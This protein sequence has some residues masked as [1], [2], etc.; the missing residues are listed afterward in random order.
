MHYANSGLITHHIYK[1]KYKA[2]IGE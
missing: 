2:T 1:L